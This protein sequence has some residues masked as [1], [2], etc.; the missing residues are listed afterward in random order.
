MKYIYEVY[1]TGSFSQAAKNLYVTQ[2]ALSTS[3]RKTEE[4]L[5]LILF[6]RTQRPLQLTPAGHIYIK[7]I[8]NIQQEEEDLHN[9]LQDLQNLHTGHIRIGGSNYINTYILPPLLTTF[10]QTYPGIVVDLVEESASSLSNLL[11]NNEIDL[12][13]SCDPEIINTFPARPMFSDALLL[14]VPQDHSLARTYPH[15]SL[16]AQ[17]VQEGKHRN[18]RQRPLDWTALRDIPL[19]TLKEGNNLLT[20]C[21]DLFKGANLPLVSI[22]SVDQMTTAFAFARANLGPTIIGDRLI[23]SPIP[24]LVFYTLDTPHYERTFYAV[25]PNRSYIPKLVEG[26]MTL[27]SQSLS[28]KPPLQ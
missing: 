5:G 18:T 20:R 11:E 24:E 25:T 28:K 22:L 4:A 19:I 6:D 26:C 27:F 14:A 10:H 1:K 7:A 8:E 17:G 23:T 21:Q 9:Q 2:P 3:I 12:T 13:F 15:L 16:S